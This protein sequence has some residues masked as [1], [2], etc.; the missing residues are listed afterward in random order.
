[1]VYGKSLP[2]EDFQYGLNTMI[3]LPY[4]G[5]MQIGYNNAF[6]ISGGIGVKVGEGI[7]IGIVYEN[8]TSKTNKA[9]GSTYEAIATIELGARERRKN[10]I[11]ID[12]KA[13]VSRNVDQAN[14]VTSND[15]SRSRLDSTDEPDEQ[16]V[17][18]APHEE[19]V[20]QTDKYAVYAS[21]SET[22][23]SA[24]VQ[25][26]PAED[27]NADVDVAEDQ[28]NSYAQYGGDDALESK[29]NQGVEKQNPDLKV[30]DMQLAIVENA[31]TRDN[32]NSDEAGDE[33]QTDNYALYGAED[34]SDNEVK[35]VAQQG[36]DKPQEISA[37]EMAEIE[38]AYQEFLEKSDAIASGYSPRV[39]DS[40]AV[41]AEIFGTESSYK[42]LK[43]V[44][45]VEK[46]FYLVLN[47]FSVKHYFEEFMEILKV[48]GFEPKF[49]INPENDYYYV[50]LYKADRYI[51][52]K[53]LQRNNINN[54]Y[55]EDKWVLWVK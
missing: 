32:S 15:I 46:G 48:R 14:F 9:F 10:I 44:H 27:S 33:D 47:V 6:G 53:N 1:M 11:D 25:T 38:A 39:I 34:A 40:T 54:T 13:T 52:I 45:G 55:F 19:E 18:A 20:D 21:E 30:G 2:N 16:Q 28:T 31:T 22:K 41:T 42:T 51:I 37:E 17:A 35:E 26:V 24:G 7:S 43:A 3:D 50:Y 23:D 8:G 49:F 4:T 36:D 29:P 12:G 5:W